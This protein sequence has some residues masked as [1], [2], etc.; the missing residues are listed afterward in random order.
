M[1][2]DTSFFQNINN[3]KQQAMSP[4]DSAFMDLAQTMPKLIETTQ[5]V[6]LS[7]MKKNNLCEM[8]ERIGR[9]D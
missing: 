5:F 7:R 2:N 4:V 1:V 3:F 6:F 9:I 8:L